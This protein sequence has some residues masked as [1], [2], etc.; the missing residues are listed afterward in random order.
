MVTTR[1]TYGAPFQSAVPKRI[2]VQI[3]TCW[4]EPRHCVFHMTLKF[5]LRLVTRTHSFSFLTEGIHIWHNDCLW[6]F[7]SNIPTR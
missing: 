3:S 2:T 4:P 1:S 7:E 5:V 6:C